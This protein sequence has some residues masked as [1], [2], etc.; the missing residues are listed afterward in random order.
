[1]VSY[2][3]LKHIDIREFLFQSKLDKDNCNDYS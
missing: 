1:M 3:F 2:E